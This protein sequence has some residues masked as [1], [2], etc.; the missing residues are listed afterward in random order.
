MT[1]LRAVFLDIGETVMRP[2]SSW[3]HVYAD[4][5][6]DH[7][8][9]APLDALHHALRRAYHHGGLGFVDRFEATEQ[10]SYQRTVQIDRAAF[11]ELGIHDLPDAYFEALGHRFLEPETW[12]LF[13]DSQPA[14][15]A[16]RA[17]GLHLG[18]ISNWVWQLPELLEA[19]G[20][21]DCFDSISVSARIGYEKPNAGIFRHALGQAGVSAA[22]ALHAGDH[23]DADVEGAQALGIGAVLVDRRG[24]YDPAAVPASVPR[25]TDLRQLLPIIDVRLAREERSA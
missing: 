2:S 6:R 3:E 24:R 5:L 25:I 13:P 7:G 22:E 20:I 18:V 15:D 23:L 14:M 11:A 21:G 4:V 8:V 12:Y 1:L 17:R 19:M 9:E 16:I 10:T